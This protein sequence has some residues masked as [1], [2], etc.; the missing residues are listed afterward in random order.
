[1]Y[2]HLRGARFLFHLIFK[3]SRAP[4]SVGGSISRRESSAEHFLSL[5]LSLS[6]SLFPP[7]AVIV[8]SGVGANAALPFA[9][10]VTNLQ[11]RAFYTYN[12]SWALTQW[13][14]SAVL[15]GSWSRGT[16]SS[17]GKENCPFSPSSREPLL[18]PFFFLKKKE[19]MHALA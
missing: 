12:S 7:S 10:S 11:R 1:M 18:S 17:N 15:R 4:V 19:N 2:I 3:K 6:L 13:P 16:P 9:P 5:S 14:R 8:K